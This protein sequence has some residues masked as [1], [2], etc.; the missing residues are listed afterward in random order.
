MIC[1]K[2]YK[3]TRGARKFLEV[4]IDDVVTLSEDKINQD[5]QWDGIYV[6]ES[7][8]RNLTEIQVQEAYHQLWVIEES[9]RI[10]KSHFES[11]PMFHWT[12]D[13][14]VGHLVLNYIAFCF[15]REVEIQLKKTQSDVPISHARIRKALESMNNSIIQSENN[16]IKVQSRPNELAN[17]IMEQ[18][19]LDNKKA[20]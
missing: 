1:N 20:A 4:N 12:P 8:A 10:L 3:S 14:I 7:S 6:I 13:R 19:N 9:F 17:L 11:R 16:A 15:E 5:A 2:S 18:F